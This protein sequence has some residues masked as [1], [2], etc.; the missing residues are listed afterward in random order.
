M[1]SVSGSFGGNGFQ[2]PVSGLA[3]HFF[4]TNKAQLSVH[5]LEVLISQDAINLSLGASLT[6]SGLQRPVKQT[7]PG[8][9]YG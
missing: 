3:K 7:P 9:Y 8:H 4:I 1:T 2:S 5:A 6:P